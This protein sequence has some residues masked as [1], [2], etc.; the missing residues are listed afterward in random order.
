MSNAK[1]LA[2][3]VGPL[4]TSCRRRCITEPVPRQSH[5]S[6][7]SL[8]ARIH[9]RAAAEDR[10]SIRGSTITHANA[11]WADV[12]ALVSTRV[13]SIDELFAKVRAGQTMWR[14][15]L[16]A[17]EPVHSMLRDLIAEGRTI[18][19]RLLL[20]VFADVAELA[21]HSFR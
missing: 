21:S 6:L 8:C 16:R 12:E 20:A 11:F 19:E 18:E 1:V 2:N 3:H 17:G 13:R 4:L 10:N 14:H 15:E 5:S 9:A 7:T